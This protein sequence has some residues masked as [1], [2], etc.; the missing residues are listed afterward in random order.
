[1]KNLSNETKTASAIQMVILDAIEKGHSNSTELIEYMKTKVF[2]NAV[3]KY[4]AIFTETEINECYI[5]FLDAKNNF[6]N[7]QIEFKTFEEAKKWL[8]ENIENP[9]LDMIKYF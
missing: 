4:I 8:I 3:K 7:T 9:N 2:E 5:D 1:M 6:M